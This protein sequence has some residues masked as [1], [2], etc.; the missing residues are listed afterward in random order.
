MVALARHLPESRQDENEMSETSGAI[1]EPAVAPDLE[2]AMAHALELALRGPAWTANPQV[3][4]VILDAAGRVIA[5]GWHRGAGTPH[6]EVAALSHLPAGAAAGATAVVTL[7]P[8]NHNGRTGPCSETLLAAGVARVVYAVSDP[9]AEAA[10]GGARLAAGGVDVQAGVLAPEVEEALHA[11]LTSARLRRPH[12]T[13]KWAASLDG[14]IAAADGS[15]QWITG[16]AARADVHRLRGSAGAI[17]VG[18][19]T[20]LA[21]D[22]SLTARDA[23]GALLEH[24]PHAVVLGRRPVPEDAAVRRHPAGFTA[25][26]GDD[27]HAV[28]ADLW[29]KGIR[30]VFVEGGPTIVSALARAGLID[31]FVVYLAP[32]LLGGPKLALD[33]LGVG[34]LAHALPL[35]LVS[36]ERIGSDLRVVARPRAL[37]HSPEED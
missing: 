27:L 30:T 5:E 22:P 33:D 18:S 32:L 21:D 35:D 23:D 15:S 6:A 13:A 2:A 36:A 19:G 9:S 31:E 20:V 34:T 37:P 16:D 17:L 29:H 24:Q 7:E 12:V 11:W 14:R 4:C 10:G 8:C 3:G 25:Y 26:P 1:R 28:L